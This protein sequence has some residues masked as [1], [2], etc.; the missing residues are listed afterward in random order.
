MK[1]LPS[2]C[3]INWPGKSA[4]FCTCWK[5]WNNY[6]PPPTGTPCSLFHLCLMT[7]GRTVQK[8]FHAV[9]HYCTEEYPGLTHA[10]QSCGCYSTHSIGIFHTAQN[11]ALEQIGSSVQIDKS[12]LGTST[13][14]RNWNRTHHD[15]ALPLKQAPANRK[16]QPRMSRYVPARRMSRSWH[17][18]WRHGPHADHLAWRSPQRRKAGKR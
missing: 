7:V 14:I 18:T 11:V 13:G 9:C 1:I 5:H 3:E 15:E 12:L 8:H 16:L 2:W 17:S 6:P 10:R 4:V